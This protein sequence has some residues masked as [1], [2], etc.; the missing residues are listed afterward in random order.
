MSVDT[1]K[2][3]AYLR[4]LKNRG[5]LTYRQI[6]ETSGVS[7]STAQAY[8]AGRVQTMRQ[9]TFQALVSAM[10]GSMEEFELWQPAVVA[11]PSE[12]K[13]SEDMNMKEIIDALR[14]AFNSATLHMESTYNK[15]FEQLKQQHQREVDR[16][17]QDYSRAV[18]RQRNEKY[19][20]FLIL[21]C[22]AVYAVFAFLH[23]D[24]ADP[25][26]GLTSIF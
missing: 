11:E 12:V 1:K 23:Y 4:Y 25:S 15:S 22:V 20:L 7:D 16:L 2:A 6:E 21:I 8:F 17:Q 5:A 24:L 19:V 3:A 13:E 10:G 9:E 18:F 14:E 26:S